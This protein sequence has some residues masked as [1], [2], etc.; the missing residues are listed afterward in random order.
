MTRSTHHLAAR[1]IA[2][3]ALAF[4]ALVSIL[5]ISSAASA[6][7][8]AVGLY[9]YFGSD[10]ATPP[11][12]SA[13]M[14]Q[15]GVRTDTHTIFYKSG[16][17]ATAW[18]QIGGGGPSAGTVTSVACGTGLS[19][20][21]SPI[22]T[23]GTVNVSLTPTT[24]SAGQAEIATASNGTSSC[25]AFVTGTGTSSDLSVWT[26]AGAIGNYAGSSPSACSAGQAVTQSAL[27]AAGALS[28]SCA[29]FGSSSLTNAAGNNVVTKSNGTNLVASGI[30]DD[31]TTVSTSEAV[32]ISG[33]TTLAGL[34]A[35]TQTDTS[36]G[37]V[38]DFTIN[39]GITRVRLAPGSS[40]TINGFNVA[41]GAPTSNQF[42]IV[43]NESGQTVVLSN[44]S[45]S[46]TAGHKYFGVAG[47][48]CTLSSAG[49]TSSIMYYD[50]T[51]TAWIALTCAS[52]QI[53]YVSNFAAKVNLTSGG[54]IADTAT[55]PTLTSCGGSPTTTTGTGHFTITTGSAATGCIATFSTAFTNTPTCVVSAQN[56]VIVAYTTSSSAVTLGAG[57]AASQKYD[58]SCF[59]H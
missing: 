12:V 50:A 56:G 41:G 20:S 13:P 55:G 23:A 25:S 33:F 35:T 36:T 39:A 24:C 17:A 51:L 18:T 45:G 52:A 21:P 15:L 53:N 47:V 37:T 31:G 48:N 40:L 16:T 3:A 59:D 10:P 44:N 46:G 54:R 6:P 5:W 28:Y 30:S 57:T 22:T 19:C 4:A 11:G 32:S 7:E 58:V 38:N 29:A 14:W 2:R 1:W 8:P 27:S 34:A 9:Y 49:K 26:A 42:V 43:D